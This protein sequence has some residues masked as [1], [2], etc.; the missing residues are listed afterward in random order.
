MYDVLKSEKFLKKY[1]L[2]NS[3]S[4]NHPSSRIGDNNR[5]AGPAIPSSKGNSAA[6]PP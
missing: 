6:H 5:Y 1:F 3:K 2:F 4:I